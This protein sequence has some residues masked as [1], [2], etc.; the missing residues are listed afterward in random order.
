MCLRPI[1]VA[2]GEQVSCR[3]CDACIT[4]R[5]FDW[6][7]RGMAEK[8][9]SAQTLVFALTYNDE[10]QENRDGAKMFRYTDVR[11]WLAR[12]RRD[13]AFK[14]GQTSAVRFL[15]AGEQGDENQRVHWHA[16]LFSDVD[17]LTV[18]K[19]VNYKGEEVTDR[20]KMI[21][22]YGKNKPKFRY[23]WSMWPHGFTVV[24]EP[25]EEGMSYALGYALKDQYAVDKSANDRRITK[26][27]N[28]S[29]GV[30][31]MSKTPPVGAYFLE[32]LLCELGGNLDVLPALR[33][34]VPE[35]RG[36]W[37]PTGSMRKALIRGLRWLND[38]SLEATGRPAAQWSSLIASCAD[39]A[40]DLEG[41]IDG[42]EDEDAESIGAE[43]ER[44][45]REYQRRLSDREIAER[46]GGAL[47][48]IECCRGLPEAALSAVGLRRGSYDEPEFVTFDGGAADF[49]ERGSGLNSGCYLREAASRKRVFPSSAKDTA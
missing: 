11:R 46:C 15:I 18:G 8:A 28:F 31:R 5:R 45:S 36:Y 22:P 23:S 29:T 1:T 6:V 2:T 20:E 9:M 27:E 41:L 25:D 4:R 7:S 40:S 44:K 24:Q 21:S 10:T 17:L 43:I 42:E 48:C 3:S 39:N 12:L 32:G 16:V 13:I 34:S 19:W 33:V 47:P 30:F 38:Q 14:T 26:A 37:S 35:L 49:S